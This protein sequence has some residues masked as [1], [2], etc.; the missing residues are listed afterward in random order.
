MMS[1]LTS[2]MW[3]DRSGSGSLKERGWR[4]CEEKTDN[5][6]TIKLSR[7]P[8]QKCLKGLT[9]S[10]ITVY[11]TYE[12]Q[13]LTVTQLKG[14]MDQKKVL[15]LLLLAV[16]RLSRLKRN[17]QR[18][19]ESGTDMCLCSCTCMHACLCSLHAFIKVR[20][21]AHPLVSLCIAVMG[22]F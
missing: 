14:R 1:G 17:L 12:G 22:H 6:S 18:W 10:Q 20:E 15:V 11:N 8:L 16:M 9:T 4:V 3:T 2:F 5:F 7:K 21:S 13:V 19:S